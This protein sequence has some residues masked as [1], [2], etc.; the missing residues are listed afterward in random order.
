ME[1]KWYL[2]TGPDVGMNV[3]PMLCEPARAAQLDELYRQ[4]GMELH[5]IEPQAATLAEQVYAY[6][7]GHFD[8]GGWDVIVE[9]WSLQQIEKALSVWDDTSRGLQNA[10]ALEDAIKNT[11]LSVCVGIWADQQADAAVEGCTG[12]KWCSYH[13]HPDS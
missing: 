3:K 13:E 2:P 12:D 10:T 9:C 4:H 11:A 1:V 7:L 8:C 6:A 5:E